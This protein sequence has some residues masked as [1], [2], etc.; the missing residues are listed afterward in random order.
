MSDGQNG[1]IEQLSAK[2]GEAPAAVAGRFS[3]DKRTYVPAMSKEI[4]S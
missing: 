3:R 2:A 1:T 4:R